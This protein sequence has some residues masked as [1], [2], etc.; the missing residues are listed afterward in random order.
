MRLTR[1]FPAACLVHLALAGTAHASNAGMPWGTVLDSIVT[2]FKGPIGTFGGI[3]SIIATGTGFALSEGGGGMKR[4]LAASIAISCVVNAGKI[5][6]DVFNW[7]GG[8][9]F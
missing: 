2:S 4:V 3:A 8:V 6:T 1:L 9:S 5:M 7:S